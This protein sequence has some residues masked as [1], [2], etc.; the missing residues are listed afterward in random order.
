MHSSHR[1]EPTGYLNYVCCSACRQHNELAGQH[2]LYLPCES[3]TAQAP[4]QAQPKEDV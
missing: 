4:K 2:R 1:M 3:Q